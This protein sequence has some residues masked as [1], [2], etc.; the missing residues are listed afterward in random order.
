M[1]RVDEDSNSNRPCFY[2]IVDLEGLDFDNPEFCRELG[3]SERVYVFVS[4]VG[5]FRK[6]YAEIGE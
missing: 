2:T 5:N 3:A 1:A 6:D 4:G